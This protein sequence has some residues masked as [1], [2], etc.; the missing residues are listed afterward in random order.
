MGIY[1][2]RSPSH[3][4]NVALILNPRTGHVSPQFHIVFNDDFTTVPYL[5]TGTVPPHWADLVRSSATIQ[6]YTEKQIGTWQSIP[7]METEKGDFSGKPQILSTSNQDRGGV[8]D[9]TAQSNHREQWVSFADQPGI[10]T[11][12]NNPTATSNSPNNQWHM[13][14]PI[15]LETSG[16]RR[17]SRTEVLVRRGLVYSNMTL[18]DQDKGMTKPQPA[19]LR[20]A[21]QPSSHLKSALVL[22]STICT[23]DTDCHAWFTLYWKKYPQLQHQHSRMPS[24]A[25]IA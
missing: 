8:G 5:R 3:A 14:P 20:P 25:T 24:I 19:H 17:S 6:M 22:F 21:S 11:E 16:L 1:V 7:D 15:N 10:D 2:G 23:L 12:I 18:T 4:S 13:P 9:S